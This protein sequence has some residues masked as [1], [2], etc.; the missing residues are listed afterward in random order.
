M[1][2]SGGGQ[3]ITKYARHYLLLPLRSS[4][5]THCPKHLVLKIMTHFSIYFRVLITFI[6]TYLCKYVITICFVFRPA[7]TCL[8]MRSH[9]RKRQQTFE[10]DEILIPIKAHWYAICFVPWRS[11]VRTSVH[12]T[13]II[14]RLRER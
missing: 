10:N 14:N 7:N 8:R 11:W 5:P 2:G 9:G 12:A 4:W 13:I 3:K 6:P 1:V